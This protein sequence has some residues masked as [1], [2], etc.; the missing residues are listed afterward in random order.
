MFADL[1][2][3]WIFV[4][5]LHAV[6]EGLV[7]R[8]ILSAQVFHAGQEE[9][10]WAGFR[11]TSSLER[12]QVLGRGIE[13]G[14]EQV[15]LRAVRDLVEDYVR[16]SLIAGEPVCRLTRKENRRGFRRQVLDAEALGRV[17]VLP[18]DAVTGSQAAVHAEMVTALATAEL[19]RHGVRVALPAMIS[20]TLRQRRN[21]TPGEL[22]STT[23]IAL[24][25]T[26]KVDHIFTGTVEVFDPKAGIEPQPEVEFGTR[27]LAAESGRIL[28]MN[29]LY[30][31]GWDRQR[32]FLTGRIYSG[33]RLAESVMHAL[34]TGALS[35]VPVQARNKGSQP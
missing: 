2:A 29:G 35:P 34:V 3:R 5:T 6:S 12:R 30:E 15:V 24:I 14:L 25:I 7:P 21:L 26:S 1:D 9:I 28:W 17:A 4:P 31:D 23:R 16:E 8:V 20:E 19:Y 11:S 18:F 32:L 33:G 22:D 10:S 13:V 27:L